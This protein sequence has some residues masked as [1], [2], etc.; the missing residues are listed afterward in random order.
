[1]NRARVMG[2]ARR[3]GWYAPLA[4]LVTAGALVAAGV[5]PLGGHG[6]S[7]PAPAVLA[8]GSAGSV[9]H[10]P[11]WDPRGWLGSGGGVPKPRTIAAAGGPHAGR[12]PRQVAVPA[13]RRV[14]ELTARRTADTRVYQLSDGRLQAAVSAVPVNYQDSRGRWQPIDTTVAPSTRPGYAYGSTSNTFRSFFGTTPGRLV[15]FEAPGGGWL[16]VGL[17]GAHA[18]RPRAAGNTVTYPGV[19][20]G[21]GLE[22]QVTP[23]ALKESITLASPS[24]A[25]SYSYTI[26]VGG[27]LIPWQRRGGQ[28]VF[29]RGEPGSPPVL[30]LPAPFMTSA[31]KDASSPYGRVRSPQV[32]QHVTWDPAA[33]TLRVTVSADA[34]WLHQPG[35]EFPVVI[36]PTIEIAPT[37]AG[38]QNTMIISDAGESTTNYSTSWRLSVGTD[39]GGA[40]RALVKFP[41]TGIPAGTQIDSADLRLYY[42]QNFGTMTSNEAIEADQATSSWDASTA[43][44]ASA[45]GN[46]GTEGLNE[47][48]TDDSDTADTAA[49]GTWPA[50]ASS[51]AT[52]GEYRYDQDTVSGDKFTWV[53]QLTE[54]G[55]YYVADHYV[56]TSNAAA[57]APFTR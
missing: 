57:N 4:A 18:G 1:V 15:R 45:S 56:A 3:Y 2:A 31:R 38:A 40:S 55:N 13:P 9:S 46:V 12:L 19:V 22:Y 26:R 52:S 37:P 23:D 48:I 41:L 24:A 29:S 42:D 17:D 27:G 39:A 7:R 53:P 28:V 25:A 35:R 43:T 34:A 6:G 50:A 21:A 11:W 49:S 14:R 47:V 32:A 5:L 51:S 54:S 20:P 33:R 8:P 16:E 30:V 44:W 36:D 10:H